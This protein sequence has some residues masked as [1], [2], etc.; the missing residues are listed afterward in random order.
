RRGHRPPVTM[1][2]SPRTVRYLRA[3]LRGGAGPIR[4]EEVRLTIGGQEREAT[5]YVPRRRSPAPAWVVLH[6]LTVPGRHHQALGRFVR[7]VAASGAVVLVPDVPAWRD[8]RVDLAAARDTITEGAR[9]LNARPE[10]REGHV[11]TVGFSFGATQALMATT[12][13]GVQD[14]LRAVVAFGGYCDVSR[15]LRCVFTGEH[16]WAG[17]QHRVDPDPYGR[18]IMT[19]NYLTR[20]P[21]YEGM[22]AVSR[23]AHE[24]AMAV[25]HG[26]AFAWDPDYDPLKVELRRGLSPA[27]RELWDLIAYPSDMPNPDLAASR[28]LADGFTPVVLAHDPGLDPL[29]RLRHLRGRIVLSHGRTDRLIPYT[30][31]LRLQANMPPQ[32]R[33]SSV[34]T[35]LFAHSAHAGGTGKL[36][37]AREAGLFIRLLNQALGA[38]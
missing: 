20:V 5:L 36:D 33:V 21:G 16:E 13:P 19:A 18:W 29:P 27:E 31:T 17:V 25:G 22:E 24:L 7:S 37:Q 35:G 10:V 2:P 9:W 28:E 11:G 32:A 4:Q 6:G 12:E 30:E 23:A 8:L 1:I 14:V 15:M 34:I 26:A 38:I 3:Y